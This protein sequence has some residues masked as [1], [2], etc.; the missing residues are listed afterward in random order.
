MR[1]CE[2][3]SC[4]THPAQTK[5]YQ[6]Q[7]FKKKLI[8]FIQQGCITCITTFT[9]LQKKEVIL[10]FLFS[11]EFS[12]KMNHHCCKNISSTTVLKTGIMLQ[13]MHFKI[14]YIQIENRYCK[15]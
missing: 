14:L 9:L 5:S 12:I 1:V 4:F 8:L 15:L 11:K 7:C 3:L 6:V 13:K 2:N 10:T